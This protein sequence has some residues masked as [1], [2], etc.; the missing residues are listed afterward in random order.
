[1]P[2]MTGLAGDGTE[3]FRFLLFIEMEVRFVDI[4]GHPHHFSSFF[5]H[6]VGIGC[7]V[8]AVWKIF[9]GYMAEITFYPQRY[10]IALHDAI[11]L[12]IRDVFGKYFK[13][14]FFLRGK[15]TGSYS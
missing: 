10:I 7:V 8:K 6:W 1:M 2:A 9:Y 12:G 5:F 3:V 13:V 11:E 4:N 15:L 14:P